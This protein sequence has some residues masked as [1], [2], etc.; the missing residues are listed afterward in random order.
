MTY[1]GLKLTYLSKIIINQ[2]KNVHIWWSTEMLMKTT[3]CDLIYSMEYGQLT[4]RTRTTA[5]SFDNTNFEEVSMSLSVIMLLIPCPFGFWTFVRRH[6]NMYIAKKNM[7]TC[8]KENKFW[9][10]WHHII[11]RMS[12]FLM[13]AMINISWYRW[14]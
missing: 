13:M 7:S 5:A 3:V 4:T 6:C 14:I 11:I 10:N 8:S 2:T 9:D 12:T 1:S